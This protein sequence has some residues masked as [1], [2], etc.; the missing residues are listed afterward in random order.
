MTDIPPLPG[1]LPPGSAG[2]SSELR[3]AKISDR[4]VAYCLDLVPF[5]AGFCASLF[6]LM[7]K[8]QAVPPTQ[9]S[10]MRIGLLWA[11]LLL[12]YQFAGNVT[13]GTVGKR[14]MGLRVVR[15]DGGP[16]GVLRSLARSVGYFV[17]TPLCNFGFLIAL[18]HPESRTLHDLVSGA[19]VVEDRYKDPAETW[20]LFLAALCAVCVLFFG[21][22]YFARV[23]PLP[24]DMLAVQK[25]REGLVILAQIQD[26]YKARHGVYTKSAADLA[27]TS[28]DPE[29]FR[30]AML[31]IYEP[32]RFR[33][34]AGTRKY[35]ISAAAKDRHKTR[36]SIEGPLPQP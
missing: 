35:R 11:G 21:N 10:V 3:P 5:A 29:E 9:Q 15:R 28:G 24:S 13:G 22:I 30:K 16:L 17:S 27:E 8:L 19:L 4:F 23:R 26:E 36:V 34:E 25:A 18:V 1:L 2:A 32:N 33:I 20:M 6:I 31:E 12:A 14:L 7:V